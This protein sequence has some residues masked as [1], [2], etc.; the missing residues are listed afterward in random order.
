MQA[1]LDVLDDEDTHLVDELDE[2]VA[3]L[4][5]GSHPSSLH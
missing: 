4:L 5:R 1:L 2:A 3:R